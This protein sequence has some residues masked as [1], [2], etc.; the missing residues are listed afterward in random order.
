L[1]S[2]VDFMSVEKIN[3]GKYGVRPSIITDIMS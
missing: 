2:K 3:F 1:N